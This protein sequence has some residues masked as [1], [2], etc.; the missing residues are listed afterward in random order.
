M[1]KNRV[2]RA[3][4]GLENAVVEGAD[5]DELAGAVVVSVRPVARVRNR[6]GRCG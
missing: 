4:F 3:A 6:C 1:R 2:L 5:F